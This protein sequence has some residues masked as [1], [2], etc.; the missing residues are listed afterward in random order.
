ML[1]CGVGCNC[2]I[3]SLPNLE[4]FCCV[5]LG[6][7][8]DCTDLVACYT[9]NSTCILVNYISILTFL[10]KYVLAVNLGNFQLI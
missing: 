3:L 9:S 7:C 4:F 8:T 1:G 5:K 6:Y 2:Y 10:Y